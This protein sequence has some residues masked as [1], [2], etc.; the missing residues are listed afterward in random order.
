MEKTKK[1]DYRL[2]C[3][4]LCLLVFGTLFFRWND[5]F[6]DIAITN[7]FYNNALPPGERFFL[8]KAQPWLWFKENDATFMLVLSIPLVAMLITGLLKPGYRPLAKY[9][10]FGLSSVIVG[11]GLLVN[12]IFKGFWGRPR[13]S[14]TILWPNSNTPDDLPFYKVWDPAFLHGMDKASFPCGHASIVIVYI[15]VFYIFM[16]PEISAHLIGEFRSWKIK[17]FMVMKYLGL[18]IAFV[19][20][21]FM[22]ITRIVQGAHFA[23]DVLWAFGMVLLANWFL[24]YYILKIPQW[25]LCEMA[26]KSNRELC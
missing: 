19:G 17:L 15:V 11:P 4:G 20:G 23:S 8:A 18:F 22:G 16:N 13:P 6:Y 7:L 2:F 25:E 26:K 24:Y 9:S 21:F 14:Q 3:I 1:P 5:G 12:T 10:I